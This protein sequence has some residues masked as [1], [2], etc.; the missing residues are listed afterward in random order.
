MSIVICMAFGKKKFSTNLNFTEKP[1]VQSHQ[2]RI[3][4]TFSENNVSEKVFFCAKKGTK[5]HEME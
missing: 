3:K 2:D 1:I 4:N 5:W